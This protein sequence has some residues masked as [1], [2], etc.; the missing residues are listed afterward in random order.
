MLTEI[1]TCNISLY[2]WDSL[3]QRYCWN[4]SSYTCECLVMHQKARGAS[5]YFHKNYCYFE[6]MHWNRPCC[7]KKNSNLPKWIIIFWDFL[8]RNQERKKGQLFI[9]KQKMLHW[10][11]GHFMFV[12]FLLV[13]W[14]PST[15]PKQT[16]QSQDH[17]TWKRYIFIYIYFIQAYKKFETCLFVA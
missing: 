15:S 1:K 16:I 10:N 11:T 12:R 14:K 13:L 4:T 2:E 17:V 6:E 8:I 9:L 3:F 5:N 7:L